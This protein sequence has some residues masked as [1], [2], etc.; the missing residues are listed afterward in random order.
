M[1]TIHGTDGHGSQVPFLTPADIR[2]YLYKLA[3]T[4]NDPHRL[5]RE[6]KKLERE[7]KRI[8]ATRDHAAARAL[9][10]R[11]LSVTE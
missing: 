11:I 8:Y 6:L 2:R 3:G 4:I 9:A 1:K 5:S 10:Q 7:A